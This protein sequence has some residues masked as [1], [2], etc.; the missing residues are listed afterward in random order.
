MT[1]IIIRQQLVFPNTAEGRT[2]ANMYQDQ[3]EKYG[4]FRKRD[5]GTQTITIH[6]ES[7]EDINWREREEE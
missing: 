2:F 6:T 3:M 7:F 4:S 1:H 5:E